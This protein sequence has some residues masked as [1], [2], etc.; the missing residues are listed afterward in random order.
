MLPSFIVVGAQKAGTSV[1]QLALR[2]HPGI[3]MPGAE[4]PFFENPDY[5][6]YT[7]ADLESLFEGVPNNVVCGTKRPN[8]FRLY[9][10]DAAP[11]PRPSISPTFNFWAECG[12]QYTQDD[13]SAG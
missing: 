12:R 6:H 5:K 11:S 4:P 3:F 13:S 2:E 10:I 9:V 1:I 8:Q 7:L